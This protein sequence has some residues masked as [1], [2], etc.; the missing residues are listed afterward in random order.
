MKL[1]SDEIE[2][3]RPEAR[4]AVAKGMEAMQAMIGDRSLID[5]TLDKFERAKRQREMFAVSFAPVPEAEDREI[6]GV[7]CRVFVPDRAATAVYLHFHGGGMILGAPEMNDASNLELS[8]RTGMA[9]VSVDYRMAPE[10]PFPAGPDDGVAVAAWLLEHG[11]SEFGSPRILTGGESAGGYMA[12]AVLLRIRDELGAVDR[13]DGANLVYGVHDWGRPPSQRGIRPTD[14][15]DILDPVGIV[16]F[17]ECYLPG[18]T[19][20]ERRAPEISPAFADLSGLPPALMSVG[21][22]DH[23]LD[24]TLILASRWAAAGGE[25]EL[26]VAPD[27]PHGFGAYPCGITEA[28]TAVTRAWFDDILSR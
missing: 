7:R 13:V 26:F 4:D 1:W 17:G 24:D 6:A 23:L 27:L 9:V 5:P 16:F 21:T 11:E 15:T 18:L 8:R 25:V 14:V 20:D 19:D 2:A 22:A 10:H 28:W 3:M 12:A